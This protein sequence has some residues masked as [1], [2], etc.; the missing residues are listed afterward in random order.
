MTD[1]LWNYIKTNKI[2]WAVRCDGATQ[3]CNVL[4]LHPR[5]DT[6]RTQMR[7]VLQLA[8]SCV[9]S[10]VFAGQGCIA[11]AQSADMSD[12][13]RQL[14]ES[15]HLQH[16]EFV[17]VGDGEQLAPLLS[18][19][20]RSTTLTALA[21]P[22]E[23]YNA[24]AMQR[25]LVTR[26]RSLH[27]VAINVNG[28][29]HIRLLPAAAS[30]TST[31]RVTRLCVWARDNA[32]Q[33]QL[34]SELAALEQTPP[35]W[36]E[37][38]LYVNQFEPTAYEQLVR[39]CAR[40]GNSRVGLR[41]HEPC[42]GS[43]ENFN[44][45]GYV[46]AHHGIDLGRFNAVTFAN[47]RMSPDVAVARPAAAAVASPPP[48]K[49]RHVRGFV[50]THCQQTPGE[51]AAEFADR[52]TAAAAPP[53]QPPLAPAP[54]CAN[55]TCVNRTIDHSDNHIEL[56]CANEHIIRV[57]NKHCEAALQGDCPDCDA[58]IVV[59][60]RTHVR[61]NEHGERIVKLSAAAAPAMIATEAIAAKEPA[62][63]RKSKAALRRERRARQ[64]QQQQQAVA[65]V[66]TATDDAE[67]NKAIQQQPQSSQP[68][69]I[70]DSE[71]VRRLAAGQVAIT[72]VQQTNVKPL[73]VKV[74]TKKKKNN[75]HWSAVPKH[76][77][78][79]LAATSASSDRTAIT[80]DN[81]D[82][83]QEVQAHEP[84]ASST[85]EANALSLVTSAEVAVMQQ[86]SDSCLVV[87]L[88]QQQLQRMA[89]AHETAALRSTL[90]AL[91]MLVVAHEQE[92]Q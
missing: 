2:E 47:E 74:T 31:H 65:A 42:H 16:V 48:H 9:K 83:D 86:Q 87:G 85:A 5:E 71:Q 33:Q 91:K 89:R 26:R 3:H 11:L 45:H 18:T 41:Y 70:D 76:E 90:E 21:I 53:P 38:H 62:L 73:L 14:A 57:H 28:P 46:R 20:E 69:I 8:A 68:L 60:E 59:G 19:L 61:I 15:R 51:V 4:V 64:Q 13:L 29:E 27:F 58:S 23:S 17:D 50:A 75:R 40:L 72:R 39:A 79:E 6:D 92:L 88:L 7:R 10:I 43:L 37:I 78:E 82:D 77:P 66:A 35:R 1:K 80:D 63:P 49:H 34:A 25:L 81:A 56:V 30:A 84:R 32:A 24:P 22:V 44:R 55:T 12:A 36:I 54:L 67:P 52:Q